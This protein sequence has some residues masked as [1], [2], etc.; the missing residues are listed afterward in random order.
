M[1][2]DP[3]TIQPPDTSYALRTFRKALSARPYKSVDILLLGDSITEGYYATSA[4]KRWSN[5]F[6]QGMQQIFNPQGVPGGEGYV[7]GCFSLGGMGALS[8]SAPLPG[9]VFL[10]HRWTWSS[11]TLPSASGDFGFGLGRRCVFVNAITKYG[12]LPFSGDRFWLMYTVGSGAGWFGVGI[13]GKIAGITTVGAL[14]GT[15]T[16]TF[17]VSDPEGWPAGSFTV[18]VDDEDMTVTQGTG[19]TYST[20]TITARGINGTTAVAHA[21]VNAPVMWAPAGVTRVNTFNAAPTRACGRIWDSG[22]LSRGQHTISVT[23]INKSGGGATYGVFI[24]G[25]MIFDG[26]GASGPGTYTDGTPISSTVAS[27]SN[28]VN[29]SSFT[30]SGVLN[31]VSNANFPTS[32]TVAV[33]V[34]GGTAMVAYTGLGV[35]TLTGC[36]VQAATLYTVA[37]GNMTTGNA[38]VSQHYDSATAKFVALDVGNQFRGPNL[39]GGNVS[40]STVVSGTRVKLSVPPT[41][42]GSAQTF[43]LGGRGAGARVWESGHAGYRSDNFDGPSATADGYWADTL[44]VVDPDVVIIEFGVNDCNVATTEANF[45]T[46]LTSIVSLINSKAAVPPS[47]VFMVPWLST[48]FTQAQFQPYIDGIYKAAQQT[49]AAVFD[50]NTHIPQQPSGDMLSDGLHPTDIGSALIAQQLQKFLVGN[51]VTDLPAPVVY[52]W[53]LALKKWRQALGMVAIRPVDIVMVGDSITEGYYASSDS[54]RYIDIV[55][56]RLQAMYNP[57]GVPGGEGWVPMLHTVGGF[58]TASAPT[59]FTNLAQR[60]T[61]ANPL[62]ALG[63][64]VDGGYGIGRRAWYY[65]TGS[66]STATITAFCDRFWILYTK[67]TVGAS[68]QVTIDGNAQAT[69]PSTQSTVIESGYIWDSGPLTLGQ[70]TIKVNATSTGTGV[71]TEGI[72][73]FVGDGGDIS[74]TDG[75]SFTNNQWQSYKAYFTAK[76]VGKTITGT[77]I[78]ASTTITKIVNVNTVELSA[79]TTASASS[80]PFTIVG[81]GSGIRMW[82]GGRAGANTY[83]YAGPAETSAGYWADALVRIKP[84]LVLVQLGPNDSNAGTPAGYVD[85]STYHQ[86]LISIVNLIRFKCDPAI[87]FVSNWVSGLTTLQ[88]WQP[89]RDAM[90][91]V[92]TQM[93]CAVMD[94]AARMGP[95]PATLNT[96]LFADP[97]HLTDEGAIVSANEHLWGLG[98]ADE[99]PIPL[100]IDIPEQATDPGQPS[101]GQVRLFARPNGELYSKADTGTI[102]TLGTATGRNTTTQTIGGTTAVNVTGLSFPV[103]QPGSTYAFES[104]LNAV[105]VSSGSSGMGVGLSIPAGATV[106]DA[107]YLATPTSSTLRHVWANTSTVQRTLITSTGFTG[108]VRVSGTIVAG[109]ATSHTGSVQV[110]VQ[111]QASTAST[112]SNTATIQQGAWITAF[113]VG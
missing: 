9:N 94:L 7:A 17:V 111:L 13:D 97:L 1:G 25:A 8:V 102:K 93:G 82:D 5:L 101:T 49:G 33:V 18:T 12:V 83:Y 51:D 96:E 41:L 29:V 3:P 81:R 39:P 91:R 4:S 59:G 110:Q 98:L 21:T 37:T 61:F 10:P 35:N 32:G 16:G 90:F 104:V 66:T 60:W 27:G 88:N 74:F 85:P 55:R 45:I 2:Y 26:D 30:G 56:R 42:A 100:T 65:S 79:N 36:Q 87:V 109:T 95:G 52:D 22:L 50:L 105:I 53:S 40:I 76:D 47:I 58:F 73:L 103:T 107:N 71:I 23:A 28:G 68:L 34:A 11:G 20:F 75:Q 84:D 89:Y 64:M 112:T 72:M 57:I 15:G 54:T 48:T 46:Y 6:R 77:N 86:N 31:V 14:S 19:T 69:T 78:P 92:A 67:F 70:H 44:D 99:N 108:M 43:S 80:L 38:V 24:E 113:K 106:L 63:S 62:N